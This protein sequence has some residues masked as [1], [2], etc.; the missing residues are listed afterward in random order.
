VK[1]DG[2]KSLCYYGIDDRMHASDQYY[3]GVAELADAPDSK[4]PVARGYSVCLKLMGPGG[5][6]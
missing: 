5:L 1:V 4:N 6:E 3:A 2:K